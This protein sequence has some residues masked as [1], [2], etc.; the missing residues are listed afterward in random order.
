MAGVTVNVVPVG[1]ETFIDVLVNRP[2][3]VYSTAVHS[4][5]IDDHLGKMQERCPLW[6]ASRSVLIEIL[7]TSTILWYCT[8]SDLIFIE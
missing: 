6:Y 4:W 5:R 7:I 2:A 3:Y 1:S 8:H